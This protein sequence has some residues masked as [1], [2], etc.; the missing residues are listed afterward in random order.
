MLD[1]EPKSTSTLS[2]DLENA[3]GHPSPVAVS[4]EN[5]AALR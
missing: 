3:K 1:A 4:E 2:G 5:L